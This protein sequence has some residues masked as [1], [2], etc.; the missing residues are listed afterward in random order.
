MTGPRGTRPKVGYR[1]PR[2]MEEKRQETEQ[3]AAEIVRLIEILRK[4]PFNDYLLKEITSDVR[5]YGERIQRLMVEA[6]LGLEQ[7]DGD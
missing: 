5:F 6:K 3:L 2:R 4:D 1:W 7:P